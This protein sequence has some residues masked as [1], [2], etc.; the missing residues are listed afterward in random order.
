MNSEQNQI[1]IYDDIQIE[2][3]EVYNQTNSEIN[4]KKIDLSPPEPNNTAKEN[5]LQNIKNENQK[6]H[7]TRRL[8]IIISFTLISLLIIFLIFL[9]YKL[10]K[11]SKNEKNSD[12]EI[13]QENINIESNSEETKPEDESETE[14]ESKTEEEIEPEEEEIEEEVESEEEKKPIYEKI[15]LEEIDIEEVNS[16]IGGMAEENYKMIMNSLN[17]LDVILNN[18]EKANVKEIKKINYDPNNLNIPSF[19]SNFSDSDANKI[20][21]AKEDVKIYN[22]K[23]KELSKKIN[24]FSQNNSELI[25]QLI[26]PINNLKKEL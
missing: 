15:D 2:N 24:E 8:I 10:S 20:A 17:N 25:K 11:K 4:K 22:E 6:N 16:L 1:K 12:D 5:T 3:S 7:K 18:I 23:Y 9:I 26:E 13:N 21:I 19:F 14:E